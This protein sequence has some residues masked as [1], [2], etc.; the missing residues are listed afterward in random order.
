MKAN[1][2][3]GLC[4]DLHDD[5]HPSDFDNLLSTFWKTDSTLK[6]KNFRTEGPKQTLVTV[7]ETTRKRNKTKQNLLCQR[8]SSL[9]IPPR[10]RI[11]GRSLHKVLQKLRATST[12][13]FHL[14]SLPLIFSFHFYLYIFTESLGSKTVTT[15]DGSGKG[16]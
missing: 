7:R 14:N 1:P 15:M 10:V 12:H 2:G 5:L 8:L 16:I 11:L 4:V 13:L 6:A 9:Q 3:S